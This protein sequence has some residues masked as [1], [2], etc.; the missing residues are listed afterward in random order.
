M[1]SLDNGIFADSRIP[2]A[3]D[4]NE[5]DLA[6][7]FDDIEMRDSPSSSQAEKSTLFVIMEPTKCIS[8][9]APPK[10]FYR[11]FWRGITMRIVRL[12][13]IKSSTQ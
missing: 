9:F 8:R 4:L 11:S 3:L 7:S 2:H 13:D 6:H 10:R 1:L 5:L 12:H